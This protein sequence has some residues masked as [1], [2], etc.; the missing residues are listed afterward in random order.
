MEIKSTVSQKGIKPVI[1]K[2]EFSDMEKNCPSLF[3]D[4]LWLL[5]TGLLSDIAGIVLTESE[6]SKW[7]VIC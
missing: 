5:Y 3:I 1:G 2:A 6:L 4:G 7:I